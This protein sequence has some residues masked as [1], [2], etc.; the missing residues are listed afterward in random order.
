MTHT[1]LPSHEATILAPAGVDSEKPKLSQA[2]AKGI[3]NLKFSQEDTER[4]HQLAAKARAGELTA[5]EANEV[6]AYGRVSSLLGIIK[7][8][9]RRVLPTF[10]N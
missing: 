3:L 8:K 9:A 5:D 1:E 6:E 7:S 10:G 2:A 4:M